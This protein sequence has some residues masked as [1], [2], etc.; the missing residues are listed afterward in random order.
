[1]EEKKTEEIQRQNELK[2]EMER[3]RIQEEIS[4]KFKKEKEQE[5]EKSN[6]MNAPY[7]HQY[8]G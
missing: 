2:L 1:M 6:V 8:I 4:S 3:N 7:C 5:F